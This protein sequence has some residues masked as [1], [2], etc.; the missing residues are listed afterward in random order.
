MSQIG[1]MAQGIQHENSSRLGHNMKDPDMAYILGQY[2][3]DSD[4]AQEI[5]GFSSPVLQSKM[6]VVANEPRTH[7][8]AVEMVGA[9]ETLPDSHQNLRIPSIDSCISMLQKCREH[10]DLAHAKHVHTQICDS[11]LESHNAVGNYI[12]PMFVDCGSLVD[13]QQVFNLL[14]CPNEIS[15][16]SLILGH[17]H[18][19]RS[20]DA[21]S[22]YQKMQQDSIH[23]KSYTL[24]ALLQACAAL[25]DLEGG[26]KIHAEAAANGY[27]GDDYIGNSLISMYVQCG[28]LTQAEEVFNKLPVR[29]V[30]SWTSLMAGYVEHSFEEDAL[31]CFN[32]MQ[33]EGVSPCEVTFACG[34]K[35]CSSLGAIHKGREIHMEATRRGFDENLHISN[36]LVGLYGKCSSPFE[37]HQVFNQLHVRNVVSWTAIIASY[38]E[39]GPWQEA[40]KL[41]ELMQLEGV[42]PNV[43]TFA[44]VLKACGSSGSANKGREIHTQ[45]ILKGFERDSIVGNSLV[46]MYAKCFAFSEAEQVF[47]KLPVQDAVS[48]T[49]LIAGYTEHGLG[50]EALKC[51]EDMQLQGIPADAFTF[52]CILKAC[53]CIRALD[54]G[55]EIHLNV[56][57]KGLGKDGPICNTLIDMYA[58]CGSPSEAQEVF[59]E[60]QLRTVVSWTSLI[61]GYADHGTWHDVFRCFEQMQSEGV[62]PN[63]VTIACVLRAC[64]SIGAIEKGLALHMEIVANELDTIPSIANSL[65]NMYAK[66]G[67]LSEAHKVF[68]QLPV[69]DVTAYSAMIKGY[70]VNREGNMAV[71][72]FEDML[73]YGVKPDSVTFTCLLAACCHGSLV[74]EGQEY[75]KRMREDHGIEPTI[76]HYVCMVGLFARSGHLYEAERFLEMLCPPSQRTWAALLSACKTYGEEELGSRSF[77]Q[78]VY[79]NPHVP[80]W[81]VLMADIYAGASRWDAAYRLEEMRKHSGM[82]KEPASALIEVDNQIHEFIVGSN[83]SDEVSEMLITMNSRMKR[84]GH[85]PNVDS[86]VKPVT[87]NEKESF[88]CE[89]AEKLALA[90][91]L[92]YTPQ[93]QTLRVT[94]SM[95]MCNDCHDTSKIVSMV[96]K[97]EIILRDDC[98]IHHFKDGSCSCGDIF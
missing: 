53:S 43:V 63:A 19:G 71:K 25:K 92:L 30:V 76:E 80:A 12:V 5:H 39:H 24:V 3:K 79:S 11:G 47:H 35:A 22:I 1:A 32:Q 85:L 31:H 72:C 66:C 6:Q 54:K 15:W 89:H 90:F 64:G 61:S 26:F 93:G 38:A 45:S 59:D 95:R 7:S 13:A 87:D 21:F 84:E 8:I 18:C 4:F 40:L 10:K 16:T 46:G 73:G 86:V 83:P 41:Y 70:G 65:I 34:L 14:P 77:Q 28:S 49:A 23:P 98:T 44:C 75:F 58:K 82:L 20:R 50:L 91:G 78:L 37:A 48:W 52:S 69:Q 62:S 27:I 81:Y 60:L 56:L 51:F 33:T 2:S 88:L 42:H 97:R 9:E 67:S 68:D 36:T 96:E 94:K 55:R 57:E 29:D 17:V 74:C